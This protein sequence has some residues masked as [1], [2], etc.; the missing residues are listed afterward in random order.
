MA[1][2]QG[3]EQ[4]SFGVAWYNLFTVVFTVRQRWGD[5][6]PGFHVNFCSFFVPNR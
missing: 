5:R 1:A 4:V 2:P 6:L 3:P